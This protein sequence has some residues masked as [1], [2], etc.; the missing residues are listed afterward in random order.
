M[1]KTWKRYVKKNVKDVQCIQKCSQCFTFP[2][3]RNVTAKVDFYFPLKI[4]HTTP[5]NDNTEN[6]FFF[7]FLIKIKT[8]KSHVF[9]AFAQDFVDAP[10]GAITASSLLQ[11]EATS[12]AH[13]SSW[14]HPFLFAAPLKLLQVGWETLVHSHFQISP[15]MFN[16]ILVC[17]G[18]SKTFTELLWSHSFGILAVCA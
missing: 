12:L 4:L 2:T 6:L 9:T 5:Y 18:H 3:F 11:Y 13:L 17:L 10:F 7:F 16:W 15:E 1:R 14:F 8:D